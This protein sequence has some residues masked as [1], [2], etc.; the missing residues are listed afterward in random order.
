MNVMRI[1]PLILDE[2]DDNIDIIETLSLKWN[3]K[4]VNMYL[5][6]Y[7]IYVWPTL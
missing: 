6:Y 3:K 5:V 2:F 1:S 7:F 4:T